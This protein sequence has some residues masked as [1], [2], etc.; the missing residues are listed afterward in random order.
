MKSAI[1]VVSLLALLTAPAF[2]FGWT[3]YDFGSS[4]F[5]HNNNT[6]P[7]DYPNVGYLPSP[8]MHGEGGEKF[9]IEGLFYAEDASY[10]YVG[11]TS[12]FGKVAYSDE[13]GAFMAGDL[14][15][16]Y[17]GDMYQYSVDLHTGDLYDVDSWLY[18]PDRPG[19]YGSNIAIRDAVGAF[20]TESGDLLG[21]VDI[22]LT[23]E[24]DYETPTLNPPEDVSGDTYIWEMRI[25][26][27][28]LPDDPATH[29]YI[30]FHNTLECGNDLVEESFPTDPIPEPATLLLLGAGL[31][32]IG[33]YRRKRK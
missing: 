8:G 13:Y 5:D 10:L 21:S 28:F 24:A 30:T 6:S 15:F 25:T 19:S 26:K 33:L 32:G 23:Y 11:L 22:M 9:D 18:V 3:F 1:L 14:F 20:Q 7:I 4:V 27:G 17:D 29:D 31:T 2:G 16:G 12:S